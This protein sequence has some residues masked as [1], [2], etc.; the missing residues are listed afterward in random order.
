MRKIYKEVKSICGG[1][2][3]YQMFS[4]SSKRDEKVLK[5]K[6]S[7][8]D[9]YDTIRISHCNEREKS[10]IIRAFVLHHLDGEVM[11]L[12]NGEFT[13]PTKFKV[14]IDVEYDDVYIETDDA[15]WLVGLDRTPSN[16]TF[17]L[18]DY[19]NRPRKLRRVLEQYPYDERRRWKKII[20]Y[21]RNWAKQ[22]DSIVIK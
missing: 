2:F 4:P 20:E 1:T 3:V 12:E 6:Y 10:L 14:V 21:Y 13:T 19:I 22:P 9:S 17:F 7:N 15:G 11:F 5:I 16:E 8:M 18:A